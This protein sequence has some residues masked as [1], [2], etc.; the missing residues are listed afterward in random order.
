[1]APSSQP[2]NKKEPPKQRRQQERPKPPPGPPDEDSGSN[3]LPP[4]ITD[5]WLNQVEQETKQAQ[6]KKQQ[7]KH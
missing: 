7:G 3:W 4:E 2:P 6:K 1:M 5:A